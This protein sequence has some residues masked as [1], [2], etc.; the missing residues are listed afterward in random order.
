MKILLLP[1]LALY[2]LIGY[3]FSEVSKE[4]AD[5]DDFGSFLWFMLWPLVLIISALTM[6][7][8]A[9]ITAISYIFNALTSKINK[10]RKRK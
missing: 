7:I 5:S 2:F 4:D 3:F 1:G 6:V 9:I 10:R 8:A